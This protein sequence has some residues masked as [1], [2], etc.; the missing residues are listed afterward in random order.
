L[1]FITRK[2]E[3]INLAQNKDNLQALVNLVINFLY[4]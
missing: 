1:V 2:M 3:R 4:P